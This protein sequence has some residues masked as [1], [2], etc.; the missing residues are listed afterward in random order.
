MAKNKLKK[1]GEVVHNKSGITIEYF[2]DGTQFVATVFEAQLSA[3]DASILRH[4]IHDRI[5]HWMTLEWHPV[6][7]VEFGSRYRDD[8]LKLKYDRYYLSKGPAGAIVKV[9]WEVDES[10][11]KA[12]ANWLS[13]DRGSTRELKLTTFPLTAP[14]VWG[15]GH[16]LPYSDNVW[17]SLVSIEGAIE[18]L[19]K[20]LKDLITTKSGIAKLEKGGS[21]LLLGNK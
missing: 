12:K 10:H 2:L 21:G 3:P 15:D 11:R 9:E 8:E 16:L 17:D 18:T 6:I 5:E 7:E 20:K 13:E 14:L 19:K 1:I 4:K